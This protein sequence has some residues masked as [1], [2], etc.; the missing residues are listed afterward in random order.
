MRQSNMLYE[1]EQYD[2][3]N[4]DKYS[5]DWGGRQQRLDLRYDPLARL[6]TPHKGYHHDSLRNPNDRRKYKRLTKMLQNRAV[7][8]GNRHLYEGRGDEPGWNAERMENARRASKESVKK[9]AEYRR[10]L[11]YR[12]RGDPRIKPNQGRLLAAKYKLGIHEASTWDNTKHYM[13]RVYRLDNRYDI[14]SWL[15]SSNPG[16]KRAFH[17]IRK[18]PL[19]LKRYKKYHDILYSRYDHSKP[20]RA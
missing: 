20:R 1:I 5:K 19:A 2:H 3:L 15:R 13:D 8:Y 10:T 7:M 4:E 17:D 18:D 9:A 12:G 11:V 6:S 16:R 14:D